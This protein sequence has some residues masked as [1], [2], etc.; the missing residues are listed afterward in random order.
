MFSRKF[1]SRFPTV[2]Y[3]SI[4]IYIYLYIFSYIYLFMFNLSIHLCFSCGRVA[5]YI[6]IYIHVLN[7][8]YVSMC[9]TLFSASS[10]YLQGF[11]RAERWVVHDLPDLGRHRRGGT[12][13]EWRVAS[14]AWRPADATDAREMVV[15]NVWR[16][17]Y[18]TYGEY[19]W[20]IW[21]IWD[22]WN[23]DVTSEWII[24]FKGMNDVFS[25]D[26]LNG[27]KCLILHELWHITV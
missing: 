9:F 24:P 6:Y 12:A 20:N 7:T 5:I 19:I 8:F 17:L 15:G 18:G 4:Y 10:P 26:F 11:S 1:S 2:L 23:D 22:I 16:I 3:Q 27:S 21:N 25:C 14:A 13:A